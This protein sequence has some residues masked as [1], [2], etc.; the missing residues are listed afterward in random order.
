MCNREVRRCVHHNI[1]LNFSYQAVK[2]NTNHFQHSTYLQA[3]TRICFSVLNA[4]RGCEKEHNPCGHLLVLSK[5]AEGDQTDTNSE[6]LQGGRCGMQHCSS[7]KT[8]GWTQGV[9]SSSQD[10]F[11]MH[12]CSKVI[13]VKLNREYKMNGAKGF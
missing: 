10:G 11:C 9:T 12:A 4:G 7:C 1:V 8:K 5:H 2:N 6:Q 3:T 13:A